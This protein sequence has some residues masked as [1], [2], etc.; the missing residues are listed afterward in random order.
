MDCKPIQSGA[1]LSTVKVLTGVQKVVTFA[2]QSRTPHSNCLTSGSGELATPFAVSLTCSRST[3]IL[4]DRTPT[5][6]SMHRPTA[7]DSSRKPLSKGQS[8]R[9]KPMQGPMRTQVVNEAIQFV[10]HS[11]Y[12]ILCV[13]LCKPKTNRRNP[14]P[15]L[16]SLQSYYTL[17]KLV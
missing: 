2:R 7:L 13:V 9:H 4:W 6:S 8:V 11:S 15:K 12:S 3:T 1:P 17:Y 5:S 10:Y 16:H 14:I